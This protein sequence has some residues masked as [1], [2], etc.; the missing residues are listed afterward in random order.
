[1]QYHSPEQ[2][3]AVFLFQGD[4][5]AREMLYREFEAILDGFVPVTEYA[6][7]LAKAVYVQ[8]NPDLMM[9]AAVFFILAFDDKGM[10]DRRWNVPLQQLAAS[11][12]RGPDLGAGPIRLACFS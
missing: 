4:S 12:A 10:I 3:E 2:L 11:A 8:V 1:M 9:S 6:G 5:V 7:G